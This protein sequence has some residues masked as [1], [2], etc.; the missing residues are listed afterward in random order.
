MSVKERNYLAEKFAT[1]AKPKHQDF[2][3][4]L[5]SFHHKTEDADIEELMRLIEEIGIGVENNLTEIGG[6]Q[7]RLKSMPFREE[8]MTSDVRN[9]LINKP[10]GLYFSFP[11]QNRPQNSP[12]TWRNFFI[13]LKQVLFNGFQSTRILAI[14]T[15]DWDDV[16][17]LKEDGWVKLLTTDDIG[18]GGGDIHTESGIWT[19]FISYKNPS[20]SVNWVFHDCYYYVIGRMCYITLSMSE[21]YWSA[22]RPQQLY[23]SGLPKV[24]ILQ[25]VSLS[26]T[27]FEVDFGNFS[28]PC[29]VDGW[30]GELHLSD[31]YVQGGHPDSSVNY[32]SINQ[33]I[34][35]GCY[36][37]R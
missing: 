15:D 2:R 6:I 26:G 34:I 3:D 36:L 32:D 25:D 37:I 24:P 17:L 9:W 4:W 23:I 30:G 18:S 29:I 35:S 7:E 19:P 11:P 12:P 5:D 31:L 28:H 8:P 10:N 27:V 16:Y 22:N 33:I 20:N 21:D 1:G 14:G 13:G